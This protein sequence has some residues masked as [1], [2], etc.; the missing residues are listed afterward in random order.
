MTAKVLVTKKKVEKKLLEVMDPEMNLSIVDIG[1]IY[2]ITITKKGGVHILMT[3][4]SIGCPLFGVIHE[5][6]YVRLAE[7]GLSRKQIKIEMTFDPPWDLTRLSK[8]AK[9]TLG[10]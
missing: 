8:R 6:M 9:A 5:D 7:L 1:L 10:I 4:T 2:K 3:L